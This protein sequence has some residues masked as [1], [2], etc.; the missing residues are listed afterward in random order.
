MAT[1]S[2]TDIVF[3]SD[4]ESATVNSI[5]AEIESFLNGTTASADVTITGIM[6]AAQFQTAADGTAPAATGSYTMG[7]SDDAAIYWDSSDIVT[8]AATALTNAVQYLSIK[9]TTSGTPAAGI[10]AGIK[11]LVETSASNN[12]IGALLD[13]VTTDVTSTSEDFDFV[14]K[15]MA[16]GSAAAEKFRVNSAGLVTTTSLNLSTSTTVS[17]V[18][19]EDNLGSDSATALA[20]QQSIK[21]YV[22][23][24]VGA[25]DTWQEVMDNGNTYYVATND[26]NPQA[27]IGATD[28][29]ELHIQAVYDT[30]AQTLDYVLFQTDAASATADKGEYRFN[31]DGTVI[32]H[33]ND[34]GINV[35]S[36]LAYA[37]NDTSVLNATTLGSGVVTSSLTTVG[38]LNSGSITSGFGSIDVGASNIDAATITADTAFVGTLTTAAQTNIT[39]LG[40]L[41]ALTINSSTV[42]LSK[43]TNFA[44]S[45]G[46]NGMS[47]DGTTFSVDGANNRVGIGTAGPSTRLEVQG[48]E[49]GSKFV[50]LRLR[51]SSG[52]AASSVQFE[53]PVFNGAS[54]F[55]IEAM[56]AATG[57]FNEGAYD[58][59]IR[60]GQAGSHLYFSAGAGGIDGATKQVALIN[61]GYLG[62]G[63]TT[64]TAQ[65]HVDQASTSSAIPVMKLDQGDASEPFID[66]IG[67]AAAN[68]TSSISTLNTSGATTDH[69]QIDLNGTKAWIAVSTTDPT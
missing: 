53:I 9:H 54:A 4:L 33:I 30:G 69:I 20:T 63:T 42:T 5:F 10:G 7:A 14:V 62:I 46:T 67:T 37:I 66:F 50:A 12:E 19:D 57:G 27:R 29:E 22:D 56:A 45:G 6:T 39:T 3:N 47:I 36:G 60:T 40:T 16:G 59:I 51:N 28:A 68:A 44:I 8:A 11:A 17:S 65:L 32:A 18:L 15:L 2:L 48:S 49:S 24:Q 64:P 35:V 34:S 55:A 21:A 58:A 13:F 25:S 38:A 52:T 61:E 23:A 1:I 41:T 43:D 31:V 26:G